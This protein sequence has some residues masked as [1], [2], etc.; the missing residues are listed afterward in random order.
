MKKLL[1]SVI[2]AALLGG[3]CEDNTPQ[4][5]EP[6]TTD[7]APQKPTATD[8]R[9]PLWLESVVMTS[10]SPG[11]DFRNVLDGNETTAWQSAPGLGMDE[12]LTM[13]FLSHKVNYVE[14]IEVK[15]SAGIEA[16]L[17]VVNDGL[18][19]EF[20]A[21]QRIEIKENLRSLGIFAATPDNSEKKTK[22]VGSK[23]IIISKC[24][25]T[26]SVSISEIVFYEK[27]GATFRPVLPK[28]LAAK[29]TASSTLPPENTYGVEHLFDGKE[30]TAWVEGNA[31]DGAGE[32]L[33]FEMQQP[34]NLTEIQIRNGYQRSP[35][36]F[37]Q[38][39][40]VKQIVL[41][42]TGETDQSYT[43]R[44]SDGE[45]HLELSPALK[46]NAFEF[47]IKEIYRGSKYKDLAISELL[48]FDGDQ[49]F[50]LE[51]VYQSLLDTGRQAKIANTPLEK[52]VNKR[53]YNESEN[54]DFAE[55][56]SLLL[57]ANGSFAYRQSQTTETDDE[58]TIA[59][60][61]SWEILGHNQS[62]PRLKLT[63]TLQIYRG[64]ATPPKKEIF[65]ETVKVDANKLS[66][67]EILDAFY[68]N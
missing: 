18:P 9:A 6:K 62:A 8:T 61:G 7:P 20:T 44:D 11:A 36:H 46:S 58:R 31:G 55:K 52:I 33:R 37:K 14:A 50:L 4:N 38:N 45:Q 60:E 23:K 25:D 49:A 3:G 59:V 42:A 12:G 16:I 5:N 30:N 19:M 17:V 24:P 28:I 27:T 63:G 15:S 64:D 65:S 54:E 47:K 66:G 32:W 2:F 1:A 39:G 41:S 40:R 53:W 26:Q 56:S 29:V 67:G 34:F 35:D 10:S 21:N 48:F 22:T 43:L 13:R 57:R 68:F 51:T